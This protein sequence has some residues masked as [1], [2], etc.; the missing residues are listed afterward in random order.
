MILNLELISGARG[1]LH[2][3]PCQIPRKKLLYRHAATASGLCGGQQFPFFQ[4]FFGFRAGLAVNVSVFCPSIWFPTA[5]KAALPALILSSVNVIT[6]ICQIT[7]SFFDGY[8]DCEWKFKSAHST[9]K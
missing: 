7:S 9:T 8:S 6:C 5:D 3:D 1:R 2:V 4:L